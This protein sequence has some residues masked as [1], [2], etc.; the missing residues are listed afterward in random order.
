[1]KRKYRW[2]LELVEDGKR[3][4]VGD[5]KGY[6]SRELAE[7]AAKRHTDDA[8]PR[9]HVRVMKLVSSAHLAGDGSEYI[10]D[11]SEE[12]HEVI[13]ACM[14]EDEKGKIGDW[15]GPNPSLEEMLKE[16]PINGYHINPSIVVI[17]GEEEPV[18]IRKWKKGKW[19]VKW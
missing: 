9:N 13:Y 10:Q 3:I 14:C 16:K 5:W 4:P 11:E 15:A 18:I 19:R 6:D 1:M 2:F 12:H 7:D 17:R 8:L